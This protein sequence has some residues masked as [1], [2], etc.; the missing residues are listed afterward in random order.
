[1]RYI[2]GFGAMGWLSGDEL[3]SLP[4]VSAADESMLYEYCDA[5]ALRQPNLR[6]LGVDRYGCDLLLTS[7]DTRNRFTFDYPKLTKGDLKAALIDCFERQGDI[8]G[9]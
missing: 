1:M 2:G 9:R 6:L 7:T 8:S 4:P 3:D 5:A